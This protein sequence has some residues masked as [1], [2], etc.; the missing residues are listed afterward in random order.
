MSQSDPIGDM[1]TRIRNA[2]AVR[3]ES[4]EMPHSKLRVEV[5]RIL[6]SEGFI[7]DY[8]TEKAGVKSSLKI[9]MKYG[10]GRQAVIRGLRRIS[11]PGV[12]RY[13]P[14]TKIPR[15]VGGTGIAILSTSRGLITDREARK[16]RIGGEV[17]CYVW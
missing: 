10:Q 12:R 5:A 13:A 7:A 15:V 8:T 4:V 11:K 14:S 1:L 17:L 9:Y 3:L 16:T 2:S 6:K